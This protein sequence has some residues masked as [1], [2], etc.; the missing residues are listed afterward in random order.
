MPALSAIHM[1]GATDGWGV[2]NDTVLRT[3]N[4]GA[5]WKTVLTT[6]RSSVGAAPAAWFS[7]TGDSWIAVSHGG[8]VTV[9][10]TT[11]GGRSWSQTSVTIPNPARF[12]NNIETPAFITFV[13]QNHG[14]LWVS[15]GTFMGGEA[16][17]LL[18]TS[19]S[20][21]DWTPVSV[22]SPQK[23]F[24]GVPFLGAKEGFVFTTA[25]DGWLT[26]DTTIKA[27][28]AAYHTIDGG[29]TWSP[30]HL[31]TAARAWSLSVVNPPVASGGQLLMPVTWQAV[32]Q[33]Q[34]PEPFRLV[35]Y[36]SQDQ[37]KSWTPATNPVYMPVFQFRS[38]RDGFG[39]FEVTTDGGSQWTAMGSG[40]ALTSA[41]LIDFVSTTT[42][43]VSGPP[44]G[45]PNGAW[46][47]FETTDGGHFWKDVNATVVGNSS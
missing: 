42:G 17:T 14:W 16:G 43:W 5:T 28:A 11:D 45:Q 41:R 22:A 31:P 19:D 4:G 13:D 8:S 9:Y 26:T 12:P 1:T 37:G 47:V 33:A 23:P 44:A 20:G 18:A 32:H 46:R 40:S 15:A 38:P 29:K 6:K 36:M 7:G 39:V 30:V 10:R 24:A 35:F 27:S 21:A 3:T 25:S 34:V 2:T